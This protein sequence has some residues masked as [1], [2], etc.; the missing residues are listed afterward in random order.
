MVFSVYS[1][2]KKEVKKIY[3]QLLQMSILGLARR[4]RDGVTIK[5]S[6]VEIIKAAHSLL[7]RNPD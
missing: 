3:C 2:N 5:T 6:V 4:C 7:G 1:G